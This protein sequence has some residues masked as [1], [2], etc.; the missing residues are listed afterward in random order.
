MKFNTWK[1]KSELEYSEERNI[2]FLKKHMKASF[3]IRPHPQGKWGAFETLEKWVTGAYVGHAAVCLRDPEGNLWVAES[4]RENEKV[5]AITFDGPRLEEYH[6][7]EEW[8]DFE[9]LKDEASHH[10]ALLPLRPDIR[11]KF[12]ETATWEAFPYLKFWMKLKNKENLCQLLAIPEQDDWVYTGGKPMSCVVFVVEMY[13][14]AGLFDPIASSIQTIEFSV[15]DGYSLKFFEDNPNHLPKWCNEGDNV[16]LPFCQLVG[17]YQMQLPGYNTIEPCP[18]MNE[19]SV[20]P[21]AALLFS[22]TPF[23]GMDTDVC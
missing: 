6:T 3:D 2:E 15:K 21:A 9:L 23:Y 13:K 11:A 17:Q 18:R 16:T 5:I 19:S 12:N 22:C 10:I 7:L 20:N 1:G 14:V 8:F 4:G